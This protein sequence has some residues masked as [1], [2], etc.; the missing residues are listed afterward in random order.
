MQLS[1][2]QILSSATIP[3]IKWL[4][5]QSPGEKCAQWPDARDPRRPLAE[6]HRGL[7]YLLHTLHFLWHPWAECMQPWYLHRVYD[8]SEVL[9]LP[10]NGI[11]GSVV[12]NLPASIGDKGDM[13]SILGSGRSPGEGNGNP[14]QYS[15]LENPPDRGAWWA[16]VHGVTKSQTWLR[17]HTHQITF[18][19]SQTILFVPPP[20]W[21]LIPF[22]FRVPSALLICPW[23]TLALLWRKL[24]FE[25]IPHIAFINMSL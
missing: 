1:Y 24:W 13:G 5:I 19:A 20:F 14:L 21:L 16:T 3:T 22:S 23:L 25:W 11:R 18:S 10:P 9:I 15:Y 8:F 6:C 7:Q 2:I 4:D 12:K 17:P